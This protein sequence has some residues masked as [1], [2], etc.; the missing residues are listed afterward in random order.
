M[1][2]PDIVVQAQPG[3]PNYTLLPDGR[4]VEHRR[5]PVDN[6]AAS[7]LAWAATPS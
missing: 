5:P 6:A 1:T 7:V 3:D 4:L 2:G